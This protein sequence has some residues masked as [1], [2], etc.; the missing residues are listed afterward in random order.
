MADSVPTDGESDQVMVA[1][2]PVRVAW[3]GTALPPA[4]TVAE[5]GLTE[6]VGTTA[7]FTVIVALAV[8]VPA[9]AVK[10]TAVVAVTDV[11]GV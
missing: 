7:G 9:V 2:L 5:V 8:S 1:V 3:N 6:S 10:V 11:G 4:V